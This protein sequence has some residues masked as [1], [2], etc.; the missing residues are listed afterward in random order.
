[1]G[2][3]A[4]LATSLAPQLLKVRV[5]TRAF[6]R[7]RR[8]GKAA[9]V[10]LAPNLRLVVSGWAHHAT[11]ACLAI[12]AG[13]ADTNAPVA[14]QHLATSMAFARME[15]L[16]VE[17]ATA[18]W[19]TPALGAQSSVLVGFSCLATTTVSVTR[20]PGCAAV[21]T[22][23]LLDTGMG[24]TVHSAPTNTQEVLALYPAHWERRDCLATVPALALKAFALLAAL[25]FAGQP[26][27][28]LSRQDVPNAPVGTMDF[29]ARV[30][31]Q[32]APRNR[33]QVMAR[34]PKAPMETENVTVR[35]VTSA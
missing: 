22:P 29:H 18:S 27:K 15:P 8:M 23:R 14:R 21:I 9:F 6:V 34:A 32:G 13:V 24:Q 17:P 16:E 28:K 5:T 25:G 30:F 3:S 35:R 12:T 1:L 31:A 19:V 33:A 10:R 20:L 11:S 26:A 2:T 4:L 7:F